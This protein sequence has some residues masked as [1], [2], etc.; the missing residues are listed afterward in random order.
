MVFR[1]PLSLF[2]TQHVD[3]IVGTHNHTSTCETWR[4]WCFYILINMKLSSVTSWFHSLTCRNKPTPGITNAPIM[5]FVFH[6]PLAF[7]A[8]ERYFTFVSGVS[9][10]H[11]SCVLSS[12]RIIVI[13]LFVSRHEVHSMNTHTLQNAGR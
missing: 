1:H 9:P 3:V 2:V 4:L 11:C 10:L 5:H 13:Y 8:A 12:I 7:T 6:T